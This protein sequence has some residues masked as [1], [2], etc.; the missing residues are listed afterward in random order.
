M[1]S[2]HSDFGLYE[3]PLPASTHCE[4]A[5]IGVTC[6]MT[7]TTIVQPNLSPMC[8]TNRILAGK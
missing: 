2:V 6:F 3:L 4:S 8:C 7:L 5:P 1:T